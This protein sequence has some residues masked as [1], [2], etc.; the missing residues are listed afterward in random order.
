[1]TPL[2]LEVIIE[3]LKLWKSKEGTKY[4]DRMIRLQEEWNEIIGKKRAFRSNKDL[5]EIELEI[6]AITKA[7]LNYRKTQNA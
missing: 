6:E 7:W 1:M 2:F 4:L 3:G 5:D